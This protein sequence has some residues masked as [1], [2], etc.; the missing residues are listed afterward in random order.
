MLCA[1][2]SA[3][4]CTKGDCA[5]GARVSIQAR[6]DEKLRRAVPLG[7]LHVRLGVPAGNRKAWINAMAA[8]LQ[9]LFS[10]VGIDASEDPL[11][12]ATVAVSEANYEK[13]TNSAGSLIERI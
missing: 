12:N 1:L 11:L 4:L 2:A 6:R 9:E 8:E 13:G 10:E 5:L 3:G 7:F